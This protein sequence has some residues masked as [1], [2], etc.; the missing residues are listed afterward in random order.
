MPSVPTA[1]LRKAALKFILLLK[2]AS[3]IEKSALLMIGLS[4][5]ALFAFA[6]LA[7]DMM[8]GDTREF[9]EFVLLGDALATEP[10]QGR[11]GDRKRRRRC[12][13]APIGVAA[14]PPNVKQSSRFPHGQRRPRRCSGQRSINSRLNLR[15]LADGTHPASR[16]A[17]V[18]SGQLVFVIRRQRWSASAGRIRVRF[19][20]ANF[21]YRRESC[22]RSY[23]S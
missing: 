12:P 10:G 2:R 19:V 16:Y 21:L 4:A 13:D 18:R 5:T 15:C 1:P 11:A 9:D 22:L 23:L 8:E 17:P 7:D 14:W 3:T 20:F 6:E